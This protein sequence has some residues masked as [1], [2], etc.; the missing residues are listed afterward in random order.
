MKSAILG[1][2]ILALVPCVGRAQS[3]DYF[4]WHGYGYFAPGGRVT[5]GSGSRVTLQ[6]GVGGERFFNRHLGVGAD[7]GFAGDMA[8]EEK[9]FSGWGTFSSNFVARFPARDN[10][11]KAEPFVTAGYTRVMPVGYHDYNGINF[12]GGLN[13]WVGKCVALRFEV[14]DHIYPLFYRYRGALSHIVGLRIGLTF[15]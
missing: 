1:L 3:S 14:R 10:K 11:K 13:W 7:V 12:G 4:K 2:L 5:S 9:F 6:I 15:R 8:P